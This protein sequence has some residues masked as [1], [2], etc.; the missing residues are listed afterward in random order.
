MGP[1]KYDKNYDRMRL[2]ASRLGNSRNKY[3]QKHVLFLSCLIGIFSGTLLSS[4][5]GQDTHQFV[6]TNMS[7]TTLNLRACD[8]LLDIGFEPLWQLA[9]SMAKFRPTRFP[10][11]AELWALTSSGTSNPSSPP[12]VLD[13]RAQ[14]FHHGV[15]LASD[16]SIETID[17]RRGPS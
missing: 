12:V 8:T 13:L 1:V 2:S 14:T 16:S 3:L 11:G 10:S 9:L 4:E 17:F 7:A 5:M 15:F 6:E